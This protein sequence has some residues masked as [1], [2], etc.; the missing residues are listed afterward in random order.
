MDRYADLENCLRQSPENPTITPKKPKGPIK[1]P[2]QQTRE[3]EDE[4]RHQLCKD[5]VH[6]KAT[7]ENI[8]EEQNNNMEAKQTPDNK[9]G[10]PL[11]RK[12]KMP[13]MPPARPKQPSTKMS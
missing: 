7:R 13:S 10:E 2:I 4:K 8:Q 1:G 5:Y 9:G 12:R 3:R 6:L 11:L